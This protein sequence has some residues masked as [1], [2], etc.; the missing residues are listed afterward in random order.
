M[1]ITTLVKIANIVIYRLF[2]KFLNPITAGN[3]Q[4]EEPPPSYDSLF[5]EIKAAKVQSS[6]MLDFIG[7]FFGIIF[8]SG[9]SIR[10]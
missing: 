7:K 3:G 6:G 5:G 8:A 9:N 4:T 10:C 1:E 2:F